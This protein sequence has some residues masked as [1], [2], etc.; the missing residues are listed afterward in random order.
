[1]R[2]ALLITGLLTDRLTLAKPAETFRGVSGETVRTLV[3]R[4]P[5]CIA[6][7]A[8]IRDTAQRMVDERVSAM[9]IVDDGSLAGIVT[10]RDIRTRVVAAG[11]A[12]DEPVTTIMTKSPIKLDADSHAYEAAMVMMQ[13]NIHHLPVT[14][15]NELLGMVSRSDFMRLET[16]HPLYLV[17]DI[18]KQTTAAGV[19]E[20]CSRLPALVIGQIEADADGEHLGK[21]ITMITDA[22]TRQLLKIAESELG[23]AP[24]DFAWVALGSQGRFEQSAKSDQDNAL[25][26]SDKVGEDDDAR[27]AREC[28]CEST[29][30]EGECG[31]LRGVPD[32]R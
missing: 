21:F 26:L 1:M 8:S 7:T 17:S 23:A 30:G 3:K 9:L 18:G 27:S 31:A 32:R 10:D 22:V 25:V 5:V 20:V 28:A 4:D 2:V 6:S 11:R 24:C 29:R 13:A 14:A 12:S 19:V 16:E 15:D